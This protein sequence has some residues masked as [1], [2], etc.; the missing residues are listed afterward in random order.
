MDIIGFNTVKISIVVTYNIHPVMV[1][2]LEVY[3][4]VLYTSQWLRYLIS[5]IQSIMLPV[6]VKV[7]VIYINIVVVSSV[8]QRHLAAGFP[9]NID[10]LKGFV[11]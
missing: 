9:N 10:F 2:I 3:Y 8:C 7:G 5:I 4:I 11:L 1:L 6:K